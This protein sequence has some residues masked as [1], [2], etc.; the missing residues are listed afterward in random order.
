MSDN[1]IK[2]I[3]RQVDEQILKL[4]RSQNLTLGISAV[5][6]IILIG[7]MSYLVSLT[8]QLKSDDI[9]DTLVSQIEEMLPEQ[10]DQLGQALV[11]GADERI[12]TAID[13]LLAEVPRSRVWFE[14]YAMQSVNK[15]LIVID[16]GFGELFQ[17]TI[18]EGRTELLPML[19]QVTDANSQQELEVV[20][21]EILN[22]RLN[23]PEVLSDV[24]AYGD[25]LINVA[26]KLEHLRKNEGLTKSEERERRLLVALREIS[27]RS[28]IEAT[29][30]NM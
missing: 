16:E 21:F 6:I 29:N 30:I 12:N 11:D 28:D 7:Y 26:D 20:I 9:V 19:Q 3:E 15:Q 18:S 5:I 25:I 22:E 23:Q 1:Q 17:N 2:S 10:R 13:S 4:N 14:G 27:L 8:S 24:D